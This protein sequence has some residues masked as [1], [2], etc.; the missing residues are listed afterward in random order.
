MPIKQKWLRDICSVVFSLYYL[1]YANAADEKVRPAHPSVELTTHASGGPQLRK[2]RAVC[3]VEMLRATWEK[4]TNP[5][6]SSNRS[7]TPFSTRFEQFLW[8]ST[9][10]ADPSRHSP[11]A[12]IHPH[13]TQDPTP[14]TQELEILQTHGCLALLRRH[15]SRTRRGNGPHR[16]LSRWRLRRDDTH[17]PRGT[18]QALDEA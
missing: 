10:S 8:S 7:L 9:R 2:H 5:Y 15:G 17:A 4:T 11:P 14:P 1:L 12:P 18:P 16:R 3:T 13:P 6:V